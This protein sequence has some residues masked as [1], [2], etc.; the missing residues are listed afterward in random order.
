[1]I[2]QHL[3]AVLLGL[4]EEC[5]IYPTPLLGVTFRSRVNEQ[6]EPT[7]LLTVTDLCEWKRPYCSHHNLVFGRPD[8][9]L[10]TE[11]STH[12]RCTGATV[13]TQGIAVSNPTSLPSQAR[14]VTIKTHKLLI[15]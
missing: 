8:E 12:P 2:V 5:S 13:A 11:S 4:R 9:V 1:M 7:A 6:L 3:R 14:R 10:H 15:F